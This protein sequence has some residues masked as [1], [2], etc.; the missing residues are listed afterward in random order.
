MTNIPFLQNLTFSFLLLLLSFNSCNY[1]DKERAS[2]GESI[3][4]IEIVSHR[5]ANRQAPENTFASA[6]KAIEAGAAY[7]EVDVR[8]SKDGVYYVFHDGTLDRTTNGTGLFAET[9]SFDIDTLDAGSW[10]GLG[11]KDEKV[12]RLYDFLQWIKGKAGVYIDYK[13][14][15]INEILAMIHETGMENDCFFWFSN[16]EKAIEFR[17]LAPNLP[18]KVN[19]S[20]IKSLDSI[21]NT[22]NPQIIECSII[23]L[24][25]DFIHECRIRGLKVMPYISGND[26]GSYQKAI[27]IKVDMVNLDVPHVFTNMLTNNGEFNEYNLI[28]HRGGITGDEF[29]EFDPASVREAIERGYYMLEVDIRS[30]KDGVLIV[31]H[32]NDFKRFFNDHRNVD[33]VTWDEISSLRSDR[34]DYSPMAFEELASMCTGKI[35]LMIDAKVRTQEVFHKIG[36]ILEKYDLLDGAYFIQLEARE[37]FWGRAKFHFRVNQVEDILERQ[38]NGEDIARH[39]FLFDHGNRLNSEIIKWC[40]RHSITVVPSVN[41]GHYRL[42]NH[43]QGAKRDIEFLKECGVTEFQIDSHYDIWLP[44]GF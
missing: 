15:E 3:Q 18:L 38:A 19:A 24:T 33:E 23:N 44:Y 17:K 22:F 6:R 34:G 7:V 8:R 37:H 2:P 5:G 29:N 28:A 9:L 32:D 42:E 35:R 41:I 13:D 26:W 10:F 14:L 40:Q 39:F 31:H 4:S 43:W 27:E 20:S 11:F 16:S 12:P 1:V 21:V 36:E 30:T 25:E